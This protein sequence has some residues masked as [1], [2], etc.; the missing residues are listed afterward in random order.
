MSDVTIEI[1]APAN[2]ACGND[3]PNKAI[4]SAVALVDITEIFIK[5]SDVHLIPELDNDFFNPL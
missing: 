3:S 2:S 4:G 5:L 1:P